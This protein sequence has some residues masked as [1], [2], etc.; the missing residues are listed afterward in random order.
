MGVEGSSSASKLGGCVILDA[1]V[2]PRAM[3]NFDADEQ[4]KTKVG[5]YV[6]TTQDEV[7]AGGASHYFTPTQR[8]AQTHWRDH[9]LRDLPLR[10]IGLAQSCYPE[11][12]ATPRQAGL[13][14]KALAHIRL[15]P[16]VQPELS[17][18]GLVGFSHVWVLYWFHRQPPGEFSAVVRPPR[19]QGQSW[20]VFA[21]RSPHRPN[22]MGLSLVRLESVDEQGLW[23]SGIDFIDGT[24]VLD[25]KPYLPEHDRADAARVG[26]VE[27]ADQQRLQVVWT[28]AAERD[29]CD[30][31][32]AEQRPSLRD[33]ITTTLQEDPR[34]RS[35][36]PVRHEGGFFLYEWNIRFQISGETLLVCGLD[37]RSD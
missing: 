35:Q 25:I 6:H 36:R 28:A 9:H 5:N 4:A 14:P 19:A 30:K 31:V 37:Q 33:L 10:P 29:L 26:W 3:T 20:G 18:R 12:F 27:Q 21:T 22:P 23:V 13:V 17:T 7:G 15:F 8:A 24:P 34:P 11:K 1:G 2:Q 32:A 16:E